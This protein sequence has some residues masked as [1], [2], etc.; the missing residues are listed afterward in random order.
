MYNLYLHKISQ[1]LLADDLQALSGIIWISPCTYLIIICIAIPGKKLLL[2]C[3]MSHVLSTIFS[4]KY[5]NSRY[6]FI[7]PFANI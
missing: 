2:V 6:S 7:M 4:T 1:F 3:L 5:H